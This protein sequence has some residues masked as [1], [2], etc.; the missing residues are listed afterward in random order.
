[1]GLEANF[2]N[3][4]S[5]FRIFEVM[6]FVDKI[7]DLTPEEIQET[8]HRLCELPVNPSRTMS[9]EEVTFWAGVSTGME[10]CRNMD[11][12]LLDCSSA[13]RIQCDPGRGRAVLE[14]LSVRQSP[15]LLIRPPR[16]RDADD[17]PPSRSP[18]LPLPVEKSAERAALSVASGS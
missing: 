11:E 18:A 9:L 5:F 17:A 13:D 12:E 2:R 8:A 3:W 10:F 16:F 6:S 14:Q 15:P 4:Q 7:Q 1:M